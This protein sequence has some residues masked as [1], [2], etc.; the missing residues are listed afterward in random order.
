M[1]STHD[2]AMLAVHSVLK[3][4]NAVKDPIVRRMKQPESLSSFLSRFLKSR[5]SMPFR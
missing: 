3:T 5:L 2:L 1:H 4:V